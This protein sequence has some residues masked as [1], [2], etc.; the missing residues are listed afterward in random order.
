MLR[1]DV[2]DD[3]ILDRERVLGEIHYITS[4]YPTM[5]E[6]R[7]KPRTGVVADMSSIS[8]AMGMER[9][10]TDHPKRVK[11]DHP[12]FSCNQFVWTYPPMSWTSI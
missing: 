3:G 9:T 5:S 8:A 1:L 10:E 6:I 4:Q 12:M 11:K 7:Y 2:K